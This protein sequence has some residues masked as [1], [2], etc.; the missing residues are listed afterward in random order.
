MRNEYIKLAGFSLVTETVQGSTLT[1]ECV[2]NI[3]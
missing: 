1:L 3:H 2:D